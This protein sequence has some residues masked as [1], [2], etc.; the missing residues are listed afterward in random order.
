MQRSRHSNR[1]QKKRDDYPHLLGFIL[2]IKTKGMKQ[3]RRIFFHRPKIQ[4]TDTR[5]APRKWTSAF[6][7]QHNEEYN[8]ISHRSRIRRIVL[9]IPESNIHEDGRSRNEPPTTTN[10][11]DRRQY[12][13]KKHCQRNGKTKNI[14]SNRNDILLG[15]RQNP[16][17]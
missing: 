17:K 6:R 14:L 9:K 11:D 3:S 16:K 4:H 13:G 8:G 12:S 2:H 15:Q 7:M 5:N 10:T 1:V